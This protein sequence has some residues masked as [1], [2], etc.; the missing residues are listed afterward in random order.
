MLGIHYPSRIHT[1]SLLKEKKEEEEGEEEKCEEEEEQ[2]GGKGRVHT[3]SLNNEHH[4]KMYFIYRQ[5]GG[6]EPCR[7]P[8]FKNWSS[9]IERWPSG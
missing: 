4:Q 6:Y 8:C 3:C 2:G 9:G 1:K 7:V 5:W